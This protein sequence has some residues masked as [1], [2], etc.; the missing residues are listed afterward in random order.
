MHITLKQI[1]TQAKTENGVLKYTARISSNVTVKATNGDTVSELKL[2][3]GQEKSEAVL[4]ASAVQMSDTSS[5]VASEA[6]LDFMFNGKGSTVLELNSFKPGFY[7]NDSVLGGN[8]S[9]LQSL[10]FDFVNPTNK[11]YP[12]EI[13]FAMKE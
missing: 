3:V 1:N 10:S 13:V 4:S 6:G 7:L 8:L 2:S 12:I 5:V 9:K 11:S